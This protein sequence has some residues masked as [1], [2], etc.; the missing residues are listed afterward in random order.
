ML[1]SSAKITN[2]IFVNGV[3]ERKGKHLAV[4]LFPFH[5]QIPVIIQWAHC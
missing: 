5:N 4:C 2:L 3:F 1:K